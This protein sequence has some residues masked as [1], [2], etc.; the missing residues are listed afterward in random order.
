MSDDEKKSKLSEFDFDGDSQSNERVIDSSMMNTG[1][2]VNT[3][4]IVTGVMLVLFFGVGY[5]MM[6][7]RF[8]VTSDVEK[9]ALDLASSELSAPA[10]NQQAGSVSSLK[11]EHQLVDKT[12]ELE[13]K[14]L[15]EK[16]HHSTS[17]SMDKRTK[18]LTQAS[19][20]SHPAELKLPQLADNGLQVNSENKD[21]A[22]V[23]DK[24]WKDL[25]KEILA[26]SQSQNKVQDEISTL[27]DKNKMLADNLGKN[28]EQTQKIDQELQ[29]FTASINSMKSKL[30]QFD[31]K[32]DKIY[33]EIHSIE[34]KLTA[35]AAEFFAQTD[36]AEQVNSKP[37]VNYTLY[38]VIPGRAWLK[39][40]DNTIVSVVEGQSVEGVGV[41]STI[42]A[43]L[44]SVT[45]DNGTILRQ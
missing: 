4:Q 10:Q 11:Q 25:E 8:S 3:T 17:S 28:L 41:V 6:K 19:E 13:K 44:A 21:L 29:R 30:S 39:G 5:Y 31:D 40:N 34:K 2:K 22:V 38:T 35:Q 45:F 18:S 20:K 12:L 43:R 24:R 36:L 23:D 16:R 26:Q 9:A 15:T 27:V 32:F 33:S 37:K 1:T 42:D 14:S 7:S